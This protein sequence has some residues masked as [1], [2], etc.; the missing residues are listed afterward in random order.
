MGHLPSVGPWPLAYRVVFAFAL[1]RTCHRAAWACNSRRAAT[2]AS[3]HGSPSYGWNGGSL[4]AP[5]ARSATSLSTWA[6]RSAGIRGSLTPLLIG[7]TTRP[8]FVRSDVYPL[9]PNAPLAILSA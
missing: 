9:L 5:E 2:V 3:A 7:V 8:L 1:N 4:R 6:C